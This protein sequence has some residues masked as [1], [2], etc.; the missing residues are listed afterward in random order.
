MVDAPKWAW[1]NGKF[2]PWSDC[3]LHIRTHA[4]MIG[5]SAFEGIRAYWN[6][7]HEELYIFKMREHLERLQDSARLL[8]MRPIP[9]EEL[10]SVCISLLE[11]NGIREDAHLVPVAYLGEGENFTALSKTRDEGLFVSAIP[12][13]GGKW[14]EVG[15]NVRVSSWRRI[16][17]NSIPPRVKAAGNY[18]NSR[19]ALQEAWQDGFDD[20]ILLNDRGTVAESSGACLM[21]IREGQVCT[22]PVTAG[23]LESI[24][25]TTLISL[26]SECLNKT[27]VER[28]IDRTE[29]YYADEIFICGSGMEVVP[30]VSV[31][32]FVVGGGK[33]GEITEAIQKI[34]FDIARAGNPT[35]HAEWR[36]PVYGPKKR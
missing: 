13:P 19:F 12:R 17:D 33:K 21:M 18:L 35:V 31:D 32:R 14:L 25:R 8:R 9:V 30:I 22:P 29:L 28:E 15:K 34:Y 6:A 1:M 5:G 4:V 2:L 20:T 7:E 23:I 36:T 10:E 27:V 24:T 16:S 26:F 3:T 11:R